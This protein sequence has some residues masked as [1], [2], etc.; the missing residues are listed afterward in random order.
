M[1]FLPYSVKI[2]HKAS[3]DSR[4]LDLFYFMM[5]RRAESRCIKFYRMKGFVGVIFAD[6]LLEI[7]IIKIKLKLKY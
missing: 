1:S 4:D 2:C 6:V 3:P 7:F 5:G